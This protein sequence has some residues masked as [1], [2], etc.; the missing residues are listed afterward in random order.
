MKKN[1]NSLRTTL[2]CMRKSARCP[3]HWTCAGASVACLLLALAATFNASASGNFSRTGSMNFARLYHSATLLANGQVIVVGGI[4]GL[5]AE[6]SAELYNPANNK[7]TLAGNLNTGRWQHQAALLPDGRVLVAGGF[8]TNDN[9]SAAAELFNPSTGT[10]TATGSMST[11]R[12]DFVLIT[13]PNGLVL[14]AGG[15][16]Y[17]VTFSSAELY[18]PATG[19]WIP[20]GNLTAPFS[21][22]NGVLLHNG[23]V[24]AGAH[25]YDSSTGVWTTTTPPPKGWGFAGL[26]PNGLAWANGQE[27]YDPSTTQ[28]TSFAPPSSGGG[29][30]I[31][32][33]E[34][35]LAAGNVFYVNARPYPT[36]ETGKLA[37][38]WNL[39]TLTWTST[40]NLNVSRIHQT[41]TLLPNGQVLVAGGE[42]FDKSSNRLVPIAS[43]E[44]YTP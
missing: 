14:A 2:D 1:V 26:L 18:N 24:L 5:G 20:T 15:N 9:F 38:L 27:F 30:A 43:A 4:Y 44:I 21:L 3:T 33:T 36:E 7:F 11:G 16:G 29:F 37:Q 17:N 19:G 13:L 22:G 8:D 10:W 12:V 28:W 41:M 23:Q 40:G 25:V 32:S 35:V 39:S 34:Q 6:Q 42:S 31:L